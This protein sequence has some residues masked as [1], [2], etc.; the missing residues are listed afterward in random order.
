MA[1]RILVAMDD[2]E[3]AMRAVGYVADAFTPDHEITL[4]SVV[5]DTAAICDMNSPSLTPYFMAQKG[6]FCNLEDQ[7]RELTR[8]ALEKAK[9]RLVSAGF[10]EE[11]ITVKLETQK[12]GVARDII[13]LVGSGHD[14]VVL[15]RRGISA[16]K[17]F[18]LGSVSQKVLNGLKD[19]T[20]LLVD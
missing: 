3:N 20:V 15:G 1:K 13:K 16:L 12:K 7:K 8:Q 5:P 11:R 10:K 4:F 14:T 17:E 2:S 19:G 18:F 9:E 6:T